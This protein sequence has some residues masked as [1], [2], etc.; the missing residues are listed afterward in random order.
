MKN[1]ERISSFEAMKRSN[2]SAVYRIILAYQ[3]ISR[4][5]ISSITGLNKMTVTNCVRTLLEEKLIYEWEAAE[6]P[7]G[8][9]PIYLK[10]NK[11]YGIFI[12]VE[13]NIISTKIIVSDM[14]GEPI[15]KRIDTEIASDPKHFVKEI[16]GIVKKYQTGYPQFEKGIVAVC[17]AWPGNYNDETG[18]VE[19]IANMP[20]WNGFNIQEALD[21]EIPN[22]LILHQ[23]AARAGGKGEIFLRK[24]SVGTQLAYVHG[25]KGLGLCLYNSGKDIVEARG[26]QG[27]FGHMIIDVDGKECECG[28]KGCLE[29]YASI[30][31]IADKLYPGRV[32]DNECCADIL[33]RA[34]DPDPEMEE[35]I[36]SVIKYLSIGLANIINCFNSQKICI[37][38]YLGAVLRGR[39]KELNEELNKLLL[40]SYQDPHMVYISDLDEW[41]SAYGCVGNIR[42]N[43]F[44]LQ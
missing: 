37:G 25:A 7:A 4:I 26:F 20:Q 22:V 13:V 8:R 42:G 18:I 6:T 44:Y 15:E 12:G 35:A 43:I 17:I 9:P 30:E 11:N 21:K 41:G 10:L 29:R 38:N 28:N 1:K 39:E 16:A 27:R 33:R 5:D 23:N 24:I 14:V 2:L 32:I 31:A 3:P 36:K 34:A 40:P 19:L